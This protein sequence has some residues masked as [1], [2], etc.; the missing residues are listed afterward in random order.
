MCSFVRQAT[1]NPQSYNGT[2]QKETGQ[3]TIYFPD[4]KNNV[5]A[6]P[7]IGRLIPSVDAHSPLLRL[8]SPFRCLVI[9][10]G[11]SIFETEMRQSFEVRW[12]N[13]AQTSAHLPL[14]A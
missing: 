12:I 10:L 13:P 9:K 5:W 4:V 2:P 3:A 6:T 14:K 11:H 8:P 1:D 7:D